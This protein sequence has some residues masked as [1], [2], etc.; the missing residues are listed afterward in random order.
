MNRPKLEY[1]EKPLIEISLKN[2]KNI[3]S[4]YFLKELTSD[5]FGKFG[6]IE[7]TQIFN[8]GDRLRGFVSFGTLE[9]A[10][11]DANVVSES[12][13]EHAG[14]TEIVIQFDLPNRKLIVFVQRLISNSLSRIVMDI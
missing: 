14:P 12:P 9:P 10:P 5:G 11:F 8:V 4:Q 6:H 13:L 7:K 3:H 2:G 1:G